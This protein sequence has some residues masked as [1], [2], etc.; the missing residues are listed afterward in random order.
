[1]YENNRIDDSELILFYNNKQ[2][3]PKDN[4]DWKE[5]DINLHIGQYQLWFRYTLLQ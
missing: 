2:W 1:M 4:I 3:K 5:T